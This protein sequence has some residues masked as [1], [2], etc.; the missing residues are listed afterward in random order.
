MGHY[1]FTN[2]DGDET[3]AEYTFGYIKDDKGNLRIVLQ[4][5]SLPYS[6]A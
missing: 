6:P 3:K 1:I 2:K 5:S 4:H